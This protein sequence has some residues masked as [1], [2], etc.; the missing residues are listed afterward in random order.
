MEHK[1]TITT[2]DGTLRIFEVPANRWEEFAAFAR[3]E[4]E[5]DG[6][7]IK[8]QVESARRGTIYTSLEAQ[9]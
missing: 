2:E 7:K 9:R 4:A 1:I 8:I 5:K 6:L 3:M